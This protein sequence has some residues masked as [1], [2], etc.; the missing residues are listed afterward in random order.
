MHPLHLLPAF[1]LFSSAQHHKVKWT[2]GQ[3]VKT[4]SGAVTGRESKWQEGVSEYLGIPYAKPP[5]GDLRF[6]APAAYHSFAS[7]NGTAFGPA[8]PSNVRPVQARDNGTAAEGI[9]SLLAQTGEAMSEDCLTINVWTKPQSGNPGK[10]VMLWVHGGGFNTG[11][12]ASPSY[13]GARLAAEHDV[14]VVSF[15]YRLNVFGFP[16]APFMQQ[17]NLGLLDQRMAVEWINDNAAYFGGHPSRI[18]LWGESAGGASVDYYDFAWSDPEPLIAGLIAE[19]GTA[20]IANGGNMATG[21]AWYDATAKM[22]CGGLEAGEATLACARKKSIQEVLDA[23]KPVG[24]VPALGMTS[25]GPYVD[26]K[27]V[28][29][30]YPVRRGRGIFSKLPL[31]VGNND[32]EA[33]LFAVLAGAGTTKGPAPAVNSSAAPA[34]N[35]TMSD[36]FFTCPSGISASARRDQDVPSWRYRYAGEFANTAIG[37]N[38]G[39]FHGAEIA[40]IFGTTELLSNSNDTAE[41]AKL[42]KAMRE[43]WTAFAKDPAKGLTSFGW[44]VYNETRK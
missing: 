36:A 33:G 15:N 29:G 24:G 40:L 39:A 12:S 30:D 37:P 8:C 42:G 14:V 27:I 10:A 20:S 28:F 23:I 35:A 7:V 16:G 6:A 13:N 44:P 19:S 1:A 2:P 38:A 17:N 18:V 5:V 25:F 3:V 22:G 9:L 4:T 11:S 26:Q 31:L 43:A 34:Y 21:E 41:E 32:N